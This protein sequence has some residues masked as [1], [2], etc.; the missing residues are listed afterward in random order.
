MPARASAAHPLW[1]AA[2]RISA[3]RASWYQPTLKWCGNSSI[4]KQDANASRFSMASPSQRRLLSANSPSA[5]KVSASAPIIRA[6][7]L[8]YR[9]RKGPISANT[10]PGATEKFTHTTAVGGGGL[11][12]IVN[13]L[14]LA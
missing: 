12:R 2:P 7:G 5:R 8:I 6:K 14:A 1:R 11:C 9:C 13:R 10:S 4:L 3:G